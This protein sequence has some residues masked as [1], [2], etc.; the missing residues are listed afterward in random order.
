LAYLQELLLVHLLL[1]PEILFALQLLTLE[2]LFVHPPL[3]SELLQLLLPS[4]LGFRHIRV[5]HLLP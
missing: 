1:V 3:K 2:I 4:N 5:D